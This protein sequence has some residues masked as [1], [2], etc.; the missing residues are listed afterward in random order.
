MWA[1]RAVGDV[2]GLSVSRLKSHSGKAPTEEYSDIS[3][4][5]RLLFTTRAWDN[6]TT[7]DVKHWS[8]LCV[9]CAL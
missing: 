1:I 4:T 8:Y 6:R 9:L 7:G 2:G 5:V 3:L